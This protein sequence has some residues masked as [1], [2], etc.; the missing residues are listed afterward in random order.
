[1][2]LQTW[3]HTLEEGKGARVI[4]VMGALLAF[5]AIAAL[6]DRFCYENFPS[7][8]AMENAQLAR[9]F[10][11]GR[12]F[13][14]DSIRPLALY[15]LARAAPPGQ[16]A[17]ALSGPVPD[18][19]NAPVYPLLL[20]G[21]MK[22][23]PFQ[24][25]ATQSWFYQPEQWIG[26]FNQILFFA[27]VLLLFCL[28]KKL[29]D[30]R[31]AWL[32]AILF[33]GT[34]LFWRFSLSG[35]PTIWL[36][37][38]AL[39]IVGIMMEIERR[40]RTATE[41]RDPASLPLAVALGLLLGL[42]GLTRYA[43][44]WMTVPVAL[45]VLFTLTR[46]RGKI[47]A[48]ML[49]SFLVV[50]APW[51][52]RNFA[53]SGHC[54][55]TAG[56]VVE[57]E[58]PPFPGDTLERSPDPGGGMTGLAP[59]DVVN[60]FTSNAREICGNDL[61]KYGGNWI[62]AF[63]LT[64]L[65]VPF[66]S[67]AISRLRLFLVGSLFLLFVVQALAQTHLTRDSPEINSENLLVLLSPLVFIYGAALFV[68]LLDQLSL[69]VMDG[70]GAMMVGFVVVLCAPL[71]IDLLAPREGEHYTPYS[72]LH[73][74][75][76]A[77]FMQTNEIM[78]SDIPS[79]VAWYGQRACVWLPLDDE[80]EFFKVNALKPLRALFLT[81]LTTNKRYLSQLVYDPRGWG[82]FLLECS[83]HGEVP[84]GFPLRKAPSPRGFLP[85]QLFLSDSVRWQE[86]PAAHTR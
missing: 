86:Q 65:F 58:T 70:R 15:L 24:F 39:A 11:E 81:Q 4:K 29:F 52:M 16:S 68:T 78:T 71:L 72:P 12:G 67:L 9:N 50:M 76:T 83:E 18:L 80:N 49:A 53:W 36:M 51:L 62:A 40:D 20:A 14:T 61:P 31:V 30:A 42:G 66:R 28:A 19:S 59:I 44:A 10:A 6:Y 22:M 33:A 45:F 55:G 34:K 17:K 1:M 84:T 5:I 25:S 74:Q 69:P 46:G 41:D 23:L 7:E 27:L 85:D 56:Y 37:L 73:I 35:L 79:G 64:G 63:F 43:F 32:A 26:I 2:P 13:T 3:I 75:E 38:I 82:P 77:R 57:Q 48:V 60:K 54:F 47:C 21:L 8:E